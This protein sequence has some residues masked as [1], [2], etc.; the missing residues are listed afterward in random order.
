MS[1]AEHNTPI[2]VIGAGSSGLAAAKN[3]LGCGLSPVVFESQAD[4]GGNWNIRLPRSRIYASTRMISSRQ[5]TEYPDFRMPERYPEYPHHAQVLEYL[6]AYAVR[7][8]VDR[9]IRFNTDVDRIERDAADP[10]TPWRITLGDGT[11]E[12]F[13]AVVIANGHNWSPN[14]PPYPGRFTGDTMHAAEY[15]TPDVLE[16]RRVLVVG[17][18]NTGCDIAVEAVHHAK[19]ALISMRRG[20]HFVPKFILGRP[21]DRMVYKLAK[22][23]LPRRLRHAVGRAV[24]RLLTGRVEAYG[25]PRPD[26]PLFH[27][28]PIVN[29]LLPYYVRH[30]AV[31]VRADIDRFDGGRIVFK[32]G[33]A[34]EVDLVIYATGYRIDFPFID[35]ALL[36]WRDGKPRLFLNVFH[37]EYDDLFVV[38]LIQPAGGQFGL[39]DYQSRAIAR[40]LRAVRDGDRGA[41]AVR[42]L[43]RI[44][45]ARPDPAEHYDRSPRHLLEVDQWSYLRQL[46]RLLRRLP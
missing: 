19:R 36:N 20:Y 38:G 43:K 34:D 44:A 22:L 23:R 39:V 28:H 14:T 37:P 3:L 42:R 27:T 11:A 5:L 24:V 15:K 16:G 17:A 13:A 29:T 4:L 10:H 7:F 25:L 33:A 30:G 40:F 9:C 1:H 26:H 32:D 41:G 12:R 21:A 46:K 6:R 35:N 45:A 2:A 8:G 18:G 31:D